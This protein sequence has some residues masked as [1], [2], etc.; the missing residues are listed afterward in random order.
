MSETP[1]GSDELDLDPLQT[2]LVSF[3]GCIGEALDGICSYGLTVGE[4][5]VPFDPDEEDE[6]EDGEAACS[7]VW[8]RVMNV[9]PVHMQESFGGDCGAV[10]QVQLE[11]GVLRCFEIPAEGEAPS[12]TDLLAYALQAMEDMKA[13]YCAAMNCD[14]WDSITSGVWEPTGPLGGQYGGIWTFTAER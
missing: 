2:A 13:L 9:E 1:L 5:Y 3:T 8:V 12:A 10:M 7:Q 11:V 4:A 6:C 14:V